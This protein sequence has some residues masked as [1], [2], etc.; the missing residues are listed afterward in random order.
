MAVEHKTTAQGRWRLKVRKDF[1]AAHALRHYQGKCESMHGHNFG[2]EAIVEGATLEQD[3]EMLLD[4]SIIKKALAE[5]IADLDHAHLN[6]T[7]P[8]DKI[9]PSSENLSRHIFT[10][11]APTMQHHGVALVEVTVSEKDGQSATYFELPAAGSCP[12]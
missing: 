11:L 5:A 12:S 4:F 10:R 8:F 6:E 1:S 3:T 7:P 9:N 2:V